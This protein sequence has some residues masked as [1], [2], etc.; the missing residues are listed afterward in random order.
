MYL[1]ESPDEHL[2][3][4]E[5]S[6]YIKPIPEYLLDFEFW[7]QELCHNKALYR[8]ACGLLMSYS[9][10][11]R[12]RS[13]IRI[14]HDTG[15]LPASITYEEWTDFMIEFA[16]HTNALRLA[17]CRYGYGELRLSRLSS[18]YR[19]GVGSRTLRSLVD[20]FMPRS[21][22]YTTFFR[23]N[24][25][26][27]LVVLVYISVVLSAMQVALATERY[28]ESDHFQRFSASAALLSLVFVIGVATVIFIVWLTLFWFHLV[29]T[30]RYCN[31][32]ALRE[33]NKAVSLS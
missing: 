25:A 31:R 30:L 14:A 1:T 33:R 17:D 10:L 2:V 6:I 11:I 16:S 20:G 19:V 13:D 9:W 5:A 12:H 26:W 29:S 23:R 18:L 22:R 24:F 4:H 32:V 3:W 15:L 27:I 7:D 21:T 8:S 28:S